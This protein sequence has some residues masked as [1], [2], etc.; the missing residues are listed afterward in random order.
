MTLE[1]LSQE[2]QERVKLLGELDKGNPLYPIMELELLKYQERYE[3]MR[4]SKGEGRG[5]KY[6]GHEQ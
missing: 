4:R 3:L 5:Y 6:L 2:V 1:E